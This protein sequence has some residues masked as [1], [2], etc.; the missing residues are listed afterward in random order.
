MAKRERDENRQVLIQGFGSNTKV[1]DIA[2]IFCK[3]GKIENIKFLGR[4]DC[5]LQF[6]NNESVV[7]ALQLHNTKQTGLYA[8]ALSVTPQES[9]KPTK[10][11]QLTPG[12]Y[13]KLDPPRFNNHLIPVLPIFL[14]S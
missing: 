14:S 3:Y 1:D 5:L 12:S 7:R 11:A 2:N 4:K 10:R 9:G 6:E 8:S 13:V